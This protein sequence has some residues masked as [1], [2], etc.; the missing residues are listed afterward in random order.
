MPVQTVATRHGFLIPILL[1]SPTQLRKGTDLC[2]GSK[3]VRD[4][5]FAES[6]V[7]DLDGSWTLRVLFAVGL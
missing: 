1:L 7:W 5:G 6:K 3:K 2:Q 4:P